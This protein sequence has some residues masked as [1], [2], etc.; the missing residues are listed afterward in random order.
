MF[1][2]IGARFGRVFLPL[3]VD[4]LAH[5]FDEQSFA[6]LGEQRIPIAAPDHFD[7]VPSRAPES[8]LEL[9]D[10]VA[11]AANRAVQPLQVAVDDEDQVVES[12]AR[13]QRDCPQRLR[14]VHLAVAQEGP[15][16]GVVRLLQSAVFEVATEARLIDGHDRTQAHRDRRELPEIWHQPRVWVRR[17][18][19]AR[20]QLAPEVAQMLLRDAP[21]QKG[22]RV[23]AR[24]GVALEVDDVPL[25]I[26]VPGAEE[27]I[28]ADLEQRR[29]R[30]VSGDVAADAA[31]FAVGAHDHR[32][33]VPPDKALDPPL[34]LAAARIDRLP[35]DGNGVDV[36]RVGCERD[37]DPGPL[38]VD[39]KLR[40]QFARALRPATIDHVIERIEPFTGLYLIQFQNLFADRFAHHIS[41]FI[42]HMA[43]EI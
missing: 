24:R 33:R 30:R 8:G 31:L 11:V 16:L 17:E 32:Q 18:T 14:L 12:L 34:D 42:F 9:L 2:E 21:F 15:D 19:A 27:V 36:R 43:Y 29:R 35:I 28:E 25:V 22:P 3:A 10:D 40:E 5:A 23:D 6:I 38:R 39:A 26:G 1:A 41:Y 7:D 20:P 13:G 4:D 37:F